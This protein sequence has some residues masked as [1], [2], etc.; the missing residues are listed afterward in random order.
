MEKAMSIYAKNYARLLKIVPGLLE[1][2]PGE[3]SLTLKAPGFMDLTVGVLRREETEHIIVSLAHYGVQNGDLMSDPE[4]E[5]SVSPTLKTV[6]ALTF[7]NHYVGR[8]QRVYPEP[9][10]VIPRLKAELNEFLGLWL[11]NIVQQGHK[12]EASNLF[13]SLEA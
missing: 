9:G 12:A 8:Y 5:I 2:R 11:N 10:L 13:S 3:S 1:M 4:M 7:T 6:E